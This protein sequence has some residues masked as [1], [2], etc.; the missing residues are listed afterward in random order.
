VFP[1]PSR[2]KPIL[3]ERSAAGSNRGGYRAL[4]LLLLAVVGLL[5]YF[6]FIGR[7]DNRLTQEIAARLR[8][9]FPQHYVSVDRARLISGQSITIDGLRIAKPT[10]QGLRDIA[11]IGRIVCHGPFDVV[12]LAQGQVP[13]ERI[14]ID[15]ADIRLWPLSNG[16][17]NI[18]EF[19]RGGTKAERFPA[20]EIRSGLLRLGHETGVNR[21]EVIC[22][23]LRASAVPS[24][25]KTSLPG[26][27]EWS[28][29]VASSY[30]QKVQLQGTLGS[31]LANW[32]A[33]GLIA[34]L[35]FSNRLLDQLPGVL[36]NRLEAI[37][38]FSGDLEGVFQ[39]TMRDR[40]LA[41]D[42]KA[43]LRNGRLLHPSVPYPLEALAC[44][45]VCRN[46]LLQVRSGFARSGNTRVEFN[47]DMQGLIPGA[48]WMAT[49]RIHD[50]QLDE[51]LY[52][53][54]PVNIQE[55]WRRMRVSGLVDASGTLVFN[56]QQW[57]PKVLVRAK[58]GG[59]DPDFFPYPVRSIRGDFVYEAGRISAPHL[60][61]IAGQQQLSGS[62]T[63]QKH[64]P[65]WLMD[66]VL[67]AEGPIAIDE[68]L[69]Q[70][71]TPRDT[72]TSGFQRFINTL[73][74]SGTVLLRRGRFTRSAER[75]ESISRSLE[76]T[77]SECAIKYDGFRY[78]VYDIHGQATLDN[79]HLI[80]REF[81]GRN[82]G[83]RIKGEGFAHCR[84]SNLESI[85]LLFDA[86]NISL[87]EELQQALPASA[88]NLWDQLQ[89]A[90]TMDRVGI[91]IKR[92]DRNDPLDLRV[93]MSEERE[94]QFGGSRGISFRPLSFPYV[95]DD[96]ECAIDYRPGRIDIR[97]LSGKHDASR[98]QS[99]GQ[100]RLH[101]D[102]SWDGQLSW[103]PSTRFVVDQVLLACLPPVLR[104]PLTRIQFD[105][106]VSIA[107]STQV[108][109]MGENATSLV[110][111]WNLRMDLEEAK[112]ASDT[113][114]G[115]RGALEIQGEN[116][117]TG[118][119]AFG[120]LAVDAMAIKGIAVTGIQGPF[121]L[122]RHDLLLGRDAVE[123]QWKNHGLLK[124]VLA[125]GNRTDP[126]VVPASFRSRIRDAWVPPEP[127]GPR[128]PGFSSARS[129]TPTLDIGDSDLRA[130]T[131]SG[132][133]FVS[134][135]QP[136]NGDRSRYRLRLVDADF[137]GFLLDL[138]EPHTQ[139]SGRLSIQLDIA[140]TLANIDSM[141]GTGRAWLR[142]ASLYELPNMVRLFRL[143]SVRPDQ[144]AFDS[145]DIA[146][147]ID[148]DRIPVSELQLDGDLVSMQ[149]SGWVNMRRELYFDLFAHVGRKSIVGAIARPITQHRAANLMRIEV[150]GTTSDPQMRRS[151]PIINSFEPVIP[152][153][154]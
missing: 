115:I 134:G 68:T 54:L 5:G 18:E 67:A 132:T 16:R 9:Q 119:I 87:D 110:R 59:I 34:G 45:I 24:P 144:G 49:F 22:H 14:V 43:D 125:Q 89:P 80:L 88:R 101:G 29:S 121:A 26:T 130:R 44:E 145:A 27:M 126:N 127:E 10:D 117:P 122:D 99:E 38:G 47:G 82:D 62:L 23:D 98:I 57:N 81:V 142:D 70:A 58:D 137:H 32:E 71:L 41:F 116:T 129:D 133:V 105:G 139:A 7:I 25:A 46:E 123:W 152:N 94:S 85:D 17:W 112:F 107:G 104:Q 66:L 150:T 100:I 111:S 141:E 48:P 20:L 69:L 77:F 76:L 90:G 106:P 39:V 4:W 86:F 95:I 146:F 53:A 92:R 97:S 128:I 138:G 21:S 15:S 148:G 28:A 79:D 11:R 65:R 84:D 64:H 118:P 120:S 72:A 136:L 35:E 13:M 124:N 37:K 113:V 109:S 108:A 40:V 143:L 91:Q 75:P 19:F 3:H 36:R 151:V 63:L 135:V 51:R 154:P 1:N 56:D 8:K 147:S 96:V 74:P 30:F 131:L 52:A 6:Q 103:L 60:T 42:A 50:L 114:S 55:H 93:E 33:R 102:G 61:A 140:G 153:S 73:H 31:D 78:P 2:D 83:A 149:G 12:G